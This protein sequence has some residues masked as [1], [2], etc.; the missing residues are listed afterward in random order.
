MHTRSRIWWGLGIIAALITGALLG[1]ELAS[2]WP[3]VALERSLEPLGLSLRSLSPWELRPR[4]PQVRFE[5]GSAVFEGRWYVFGG[6]E[7]P[8]LEATARV[9][10]YDP[11]TGRWGRLADMPVALTH[12]NAALAGERIWFAGGFVGTNPGPATSDTW[13]YDPRTDTWDRGPSLPSPRGGGSLVVAGDGALHYFGGWREDRRTDASDHWR[14]APGDSVWQPRA[15]LPVARGHMG[16]IEQGGFLYAIGGCLYHDP[17][18]L[19]LRVVHRYSPETDQW[20]ERAMLPRPRSHMEPGTLAF[21]GRI[22]LVG[23]RSKPHGDA[24]VADV[25]AYDPV[26]DQWSHQLTLPRG[27]MAPASALLGDDLFVTVGGEGGGIPRNKQSWAAPLGAPWRTGPPLPVPMGETAAA[28]IHG[29]LFLAGEGTASTQ[30]LDLGSGQWR[31]EGQVQ[32]RP[33]GGLGHA[34]ELVGGDWYLIGG[35]RPMRT[36]LEVQVYDPRANEWRMGPPLPQGVGGAASGVIDGRVYLAGGLADSGVTRSGLVL[37][38]TTGTWSPIAPMPVARHHAGYGTD[39]KLLYVFGGSGPGPDGVARDAS[40][41]LQVYDPVAN[42]W[43][44]SGGE[45]GALPPLPRPAS[46]TGRAVFHNGEFYLIGGRTPETG[47]RSRGTVTGR[48]DIFDPRTNTWRQGPAL[49]TPRR[50]ATPVPWG[51]EIWVAGGTSRGTTPVSR[52]VEV[53]LP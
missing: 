7:N 11:A 47:D 10:R 23:G 15:P 38:P 29:T 43:S 2:R 41:D 30:A 5:S 53:L 44:A 26:S 49:P 34:S 9:D 6:F 19:D 20:E 33:V 22:L 28:V 31:P 18:P 17:F 8:Q 13:R 36:M 51:G 52:V 37:D 24:S 48:V 14:L 32:D 1:I 4:S 46:G 42:L 35:I 3:L 25:L 16:A 40:T 50:G 27:L 45:A 39:G 21:R 12:A